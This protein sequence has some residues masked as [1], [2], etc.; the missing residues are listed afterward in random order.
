MI[1][2]ISSKKDIASK[3][4]AEELIYE[5]KFEK[6]KEMYRNFPIYQKIIGSREIRLITVDR[7]LVLEEKITE[8]FN[9]ELIIFISR[10]ESKSGK[11]IL[12]VHTP[13]NLGTAQFGGVSRKVSIA[14]ANNMR[15]ALIQIMIQKKK[16]GLNKFEVY[17]EGTHH[18]PTLDF[19]SMFLEIGSTPRDWTNS[20]AA[21]VVA[22]S[23]VTSMDNDLKVPVALGLGGPHCNRRFTRLAIEH[24][25][26]FGHI[27]PNYL[28]GILDAEVLK[29]C[30]KRTSEEVKMIILDWEGIDGRER[31]SLIGKLEKF[32]LEI[33]RVNDFK[34][35]QLRNDAYR[36]CQKKQL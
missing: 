5:Y 31:M 4:I 21:K 14:P 13:G 28:L 7:E 32:P 12:S 19:P 24:N 36:P 30:I 18:G 9:P 2:C 29:K 3:K 6:M 16:I 35:G 1:L 17:Y 8:V 25:I 22:R 26:A 23:I 34:R 15:N 10:H 27:I 20:E 33:C 11:S